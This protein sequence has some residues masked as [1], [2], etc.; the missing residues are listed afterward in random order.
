MKGV[1]SQMLQNFFRKMEN[2]FSIRNW[3]KW[4]KRKVHLAICKTKLFFT[5]IFQI[6]GC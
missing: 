5:M 1:L 4:E 2:F 3:M 6:F